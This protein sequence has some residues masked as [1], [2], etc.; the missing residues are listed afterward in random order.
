M[1]L[2]NRHGVQVR[3]R[4]CVESVDPEMAKDMAVIGYR[5]QGMTYR[6]IGRIMGVSHVA[7]YKRLRAIPSEARRHY[8]SV[9][10]GAMGRAVSE[11][12]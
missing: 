10:L 4:R 6:Q 2:V 3:A 8:G 11:A 1:S 12:S 5:A 9:A 7:V